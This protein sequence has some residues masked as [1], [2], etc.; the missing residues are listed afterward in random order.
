[1]IASSTYDI[2][3][4]ETE[5]DHFLPNDLEAFVSDVKKILQD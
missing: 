2:N 1:M 4:E 5:I 3:G